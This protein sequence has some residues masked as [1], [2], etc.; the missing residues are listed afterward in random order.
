MKTRILIIALF[1][2]VLAGCGKEYIYVNADSDDTDPTI[3]DSSDSIPDSTDNTDDEPD[4]DF[5]TVAEALSCDYGEQVCVRGY[6]VA[7]CTKNISN[8]DYTYPF[9]GSTAIILADDTMGVDGVAPQNIMPVCL[10]EWTELRN[11]LNLETNPELHNKR[12]YITG[13]ITKYMY[14][15]GLKDVYSAYVED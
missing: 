7:S 9:K 1:A 10:T 13:T 14:R 6:I 15:K 4:D 8:A 2:A 5:I 11:G 12:A 3:T